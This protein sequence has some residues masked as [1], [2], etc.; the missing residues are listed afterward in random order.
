M[1]VFREL[2][3]HYGPRRSNMIAR[4]EDT[5]RGRETLD[6][7]AFVTLQ[8]PTVTYCSTRRSTRH[9][10]GQQSYR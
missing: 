8:K 4:E 3:A 6:R 9:A 7:I 1:T 5:P 10:G 2:Y